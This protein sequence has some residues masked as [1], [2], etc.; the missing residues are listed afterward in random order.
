MEISP[1]EFYNILLHLLTK[2]IDEG[3]ADAILLLIVETRLGWKRHHI[4][5]ND[6][7]QTQEAELDHCKAIVQQVT[8]GYPVQYAL[9]SAEF[10]G[11]RF[12]VN[13]HVLIPRP[14][15]EELVDLCLQKE[16]KGN[17]LN[18]V[19]IGTGSG[20]IPI[21]IKKTLPRAK[22]YASDVSIEALKLASKNAIS[23]HCDVTFIQNDILKD[24]LPLSTLD[25]IISN[26]P[27]IGY[28][29]SNLMTPNT[30]HEPEIALFVDDN[31]PLLF[32][33]KIGT[34]GLQKLIQGGRLYF[35]INE[36]YAKETVKVLDALG[37]LKIEVHKDINGKDRM[38]MAVKPGSN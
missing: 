27:Y 33:K 30:R 1:K 24:D 16:S 11:L 15:T 3:E 8:E 35:E 7:L 36:Q 5:V 19:D 6:P 12:E 17:S 20:C 9:G 13:K 26:P 28:A 32:Y 14:E 10:Y 38:V 25:C 4:L 18:I 22:V 37:Y 2:N 29:E 23:N 31:D 21:S 34:I